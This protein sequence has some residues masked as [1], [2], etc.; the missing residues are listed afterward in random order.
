LAEFVLANQE[1]MPEHPLIV[2]DDRFEYAEEIEGAARVVL[3]TLFGLPTAVP[4]AGN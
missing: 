3:E 4:S 1:K 2:L